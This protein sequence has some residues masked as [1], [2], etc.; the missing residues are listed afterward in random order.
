M[1]RKKP[2]IVMLL[3]GLSENLIR[4]GHAPNLERYSQETGLCAFDPQL[5]ALTLSMQATFTTG[6]PPSRHGIV[7][8]GFF[9]RTWLEH[10]FWNAPAPLVECERFWQKPEAKGYRCGALFWWNCL[11]TDLDVYMNVA[12]IH[13]PGG[14]TVSSCYSAPSD[15]YPAIEKELGPFPLHRFWGPAITLESSAWILAAT[16]RVARE[17]DLDL[18]LTYIPHMDFS[19]QRSGPGS[20]EANQHLQQLDDLLKPILEQALEGKIDLMLL[21]EY[22]I[23]KVGGAVGLNRALLEKDGFRVRTVN[24]LDYPDLVGS[25]A[26]AICDHQVAHVYIKRSEDTESVSGYLSGL[27]GVAKVL[28][29][30]GKAGCGLDHPRSGDLVVLSAPDRWFEYTW[31]TDPAR[32]PEYAFT[33]DIHRKIGY[34][35][36]ELIWDPQN[37]RIAGDPG[38]IKGSHGLIPDDPGDRPVAIGKG[39]KTT[40]I[41]ALKIAELIVKLLADQEKAI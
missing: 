3:A 21:S 35:P 2:L 40:G 13:G 6:A 26:F 22:G 4:S 36:L 9:D 39:V 20:D 14:K 38:L 27:P 31:W 1:R 28:D 33:V 17:A 37:S 15:L 10:R 11:G 24:G 5:P 16:E 30:E 25:S 18:L 19:L 7:G 29:K 41:D 34:D 8:N 12:P 23:S 32:A